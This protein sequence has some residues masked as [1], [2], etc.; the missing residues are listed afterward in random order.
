MHDVMQGLLEADDVTC[1]AGCVDEI[2]RLLRKIREDRLSD[3]NKSLAVLAS[4]RRISSRVACL[5]L[6]R[7]MSDVV[8]EVRANVRAC[9]RRGAVLSSS[10]T[11]RMSDNEI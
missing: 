4:R 9:W 2:D 1:D 7:H 3:R 8:S 6:V 5:F 11:D 10:A